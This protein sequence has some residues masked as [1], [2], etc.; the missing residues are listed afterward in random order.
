M[1][2]K[3]RI[4]T[5]RFGNPYQVVGLKDTKGTGFPKGYAELG[6]K[7]YKIEVSDS[8]KEGVEAWVRITRVE[9]N[10]RQTSM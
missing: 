6:G 7:L 8:K 9:Q 4:S 2:G 10:K 3:K 1:Q 5:D